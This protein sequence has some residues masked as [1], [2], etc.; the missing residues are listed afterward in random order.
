MQVKKE[1]GEQQQKD[2][3]S[4]IGT[5]EENELKRNMPQP[6]QFLVKLR[7]MNLVSSGR[8]F[9]PTPQHLLRRPVEQAGIPPTESIA[10]QPPI[11]KNPVAKKG[12][13]SQANEKPKPAAKKRVARKP[14]DDQLEA[15]KLMKP[16]DPVTPLASLKRYEQEFGGYS[17]PG[18]A[19]GASVTDSP[20][21]NANSSS[22]NEVFRESGVNSIAC[23]LQPSLSLP[24]AVQSHSP[25]YSE[26]G[27]EFDSQHRIE[28]DRH[29]E[30]LEAINKLSLGD[31]SVTV[32]TL[33]NLTKMAIESQ[34]KVTLAALEAQKRN[35]ESVSEMILMFDKTVLVSN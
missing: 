1:K 33:A 9:I 3:T 32:V 29:P 35:T 10:V 34:T 11:K 5:D 2:R 23:H 15:E 18:S 12:T 22:G 19:A 26:R 27:I 14:V 8:K 17:T 6:G 13:S 4:R 20:S 25:A 7:E 28:F 30:L 21:N 31:E 24:A 16:T